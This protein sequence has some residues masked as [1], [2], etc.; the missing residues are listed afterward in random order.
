MSTNQATPVRELFEVPQHLSPRLAW[1][2][3][4]RVVVERVNAETSGGFKWI[5]RTEHPPLAGFWPPNS[6]GGGE[7]EDEAIADF[8]IAAGIR[9]WNEELPSTP[10]ATK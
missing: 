5:C 1:I 2:K 4:H 6:I 10:E 9:L 8:A 3:R 7:T